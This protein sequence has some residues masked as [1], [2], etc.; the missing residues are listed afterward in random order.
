MSYF[1]SNPSSLKPPP[2]IHRRPNINDLILSPK[3][4][5]PPY[6][7]I[8]LLTGVQPMRKSLKKS[9]HSRTMSFFT[10]S[11]G[12]IPKNQKLQPQLPS[13]PFR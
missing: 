5:A 10:S 7:K 1:T 13:S 11:G 2:G 4:G 3:E 9:N 12:G 8:N 6:G